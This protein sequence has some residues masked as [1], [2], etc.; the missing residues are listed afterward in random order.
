MEEKAFIEKQRDTIESVEVELLAVVKKAKSDLDIEV[1]RLRQE[2][3]EKKTPM[4]KK[5]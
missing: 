2:T 4:K 3:K 5:N 1:N